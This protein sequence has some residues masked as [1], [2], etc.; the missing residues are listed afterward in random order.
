MGM[1]DHLP[2]AADVD[3][4]LGARRATPKHDMEPR[5][6]SREKRRK[7]KL[8]AEDVFRDAVWARDGR[9]C[10]ATGAPLV[11]SGTIDDKK[12]GEVDHSIRRSTDPSLIYE[13]TNGLLLQKFL[14]RLREVRCPRAPEFRMF[15][16][17]GPEDRGE[18]QEFTWRD[19]DGNVTR[20]RVG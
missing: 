19:V 10:R 9:R 8:A 18:P 17:T 7:A 16:Y 13:P 1:F 6:V 14:N 3:E 5:I 11:R 20:R 12:L 4:A 15:D 2:T